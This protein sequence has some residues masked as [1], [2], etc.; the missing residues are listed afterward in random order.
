[1]F[2]GTLQGPY[3]ERM[4]GSMLVR[5]YDLVVVGERIESDLKSGKI[6]SVVGTSN[7]AK[8]LYVSFA[9]KKEGE[10]NNTSVA[11]GRGRAY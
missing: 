6:P 11:R 4:V 9:K 8:K 10:T 7:G 5:F 2:M 3:Y 1:M